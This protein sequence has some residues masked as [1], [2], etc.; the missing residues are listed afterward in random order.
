MTSNGRGGQVQLCFEQKAPFHPTRSLKVIDLNAN[1][2][3]VY[4]FILVIN[5]NLYGI[6]KGY[7]ETGL[8]T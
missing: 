4:E 1:R 7:G 2:K 6:L 5:S 8:E 3:P